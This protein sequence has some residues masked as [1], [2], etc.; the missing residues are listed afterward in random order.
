M[1]VAA[2]PQAAGCVACGA[3]LA[4]PAT[5]CFECGAGPLYG[6]SD[7]EGWSVLVE[8]APEAAKVARAVSER[9]AGVK[10]GA[11]ATAL[12][13]VHPAWLAAGL[14]EESAQ[15]L[16]RWV[17]SLGARAR[18]QQGPARPPGKA[19][20]MLSPE[21][22]AMALLATPLVAF[23][24]TRVLGGIVLG[25]AVLVGLLRVRAAPPHEPFFRP[26]PG[27]QPNAALDAA[28]SRLVDARKKAT[29]PTRTALEN[30][31]RSSRELL[32]LAADHPT[33][34]GTAHAVAL[35]EACE[36]LLARAALR[37]EAGQGATLFA[38]TRAV[39][40]SSQSLR[41]ASAEPALLAWEEAA[42]EVALEAARL[43]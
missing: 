24:P 12:G 20:R 2:S 8:S 27:D 6:E 37:A 28:I 5:V 35:R 18:T 26:S 36:I 25:A 29:G 16:A 40:M 15:E 11:L 13:R 3:D 7:G 31:L 30:L 19:W 9:L 4:P 32:R 17:G 38:A 33:M 23:G 10:V 34:A 41:E 14:T 1:M 43:E 39:K 42:R 21:T 22:V